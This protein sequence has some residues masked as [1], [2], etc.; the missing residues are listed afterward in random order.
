MTRTDINEMFNDIQTQVND[1]KKAL[2]SRIK[3][4]QFYSSKFYD[5]K[6]LERILII[7]KIL[8]L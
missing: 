2:E 3:E 4:D 8:H 7:E 1:I 5:A 6:D